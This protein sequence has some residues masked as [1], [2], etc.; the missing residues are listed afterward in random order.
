[1]EIRRILKRGR[2]KLPVVTGAGKVDERR[3]TREPSL[4]L[5]RYCAYMYGCIVPC[6]LQDSFILEVART[7]PSYSN[8]SLK[9]DFKVQL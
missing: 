3:P 9:V 1:M 6:I 4:N 5:A 2:D 8:S 7:G